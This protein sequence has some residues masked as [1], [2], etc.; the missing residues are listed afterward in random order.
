MKN[1]FTTVVYLVGTSFQIW[2]VI[3]DQWLEPILIALMQIGI[4][5]DQIHDTLK[6]TKK[7]Q[8]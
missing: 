4:I 3:N 8:P 7:G 5:L 2:F 6:A 1:I